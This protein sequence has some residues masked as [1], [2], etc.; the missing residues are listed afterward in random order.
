MRIV[1][2][3]GNLD[4]LHS[5]TKILANKLRWRENRGPGAKARSNRPHLSDS[6]KKLETPSVSILLDKDL[7]LAA[8]FVAVADFA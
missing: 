2:S 3:K 4:F 8:S 6:R 1:N 7:T 5:W